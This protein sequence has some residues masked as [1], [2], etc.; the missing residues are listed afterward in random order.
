MIFSVTTPSAFALAYLAR[1]NPSDGGSQCILNFEGHYD[2]L[3]F[4]YSALTTLVHGN[5][6]PVGFCRV[7]TSVEALLGNLVLG[8]LAAMF[9]QLMVP[10][11]VD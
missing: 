5:L 9:Y 10:S 6:A 2:A 7:L 11:E 3:Y 8:V 1:E 4:S